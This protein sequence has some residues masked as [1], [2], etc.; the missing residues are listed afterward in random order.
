[1]KVA[2]GVFSIHFQTTCLW[3]PEVGWSPL[4]KGEPSDISVG[5]AMRRDR[6]GF[7]LLGRGLGVSPRIIFFP[8]STPHGEGARG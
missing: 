3:R 4:R 7:A 1:V 8:L 5:V 6:E 2:T